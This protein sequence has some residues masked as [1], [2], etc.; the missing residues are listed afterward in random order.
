MGSRHPQPNR[1]T[2]WCTSS[3]ASPRA[4]RADRAHSP[5]GRIG[6]RASAAPPWPVCQ[7]GRGYNPS[8]C[9]NGHNA[10]RYSRF[11]IAAAWHAVHLVLFGIGSGVG[12][13]Q[14][15]CYNITLSVLRS[16][17]VYPVPRPRFSTSLSIMVLLRQ[18]K[19]LILLD[20]LFS[21]R[22]YVRQP[23]A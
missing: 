16:P 20:T 8:L 1:Q 19:P 9:S 17:L 21:F 10:H 11:D 14:M 4:G 13:A 18:A 22:Q 23:P 2:A 7:G 12:Q 15:K 3:H 6:Q 5:A